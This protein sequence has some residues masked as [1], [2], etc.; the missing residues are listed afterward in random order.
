MK[1]IFL[2]L[3]FF[4]T[5]SANAYEFFDTKTQCNTSSE[6]N[7]PN[8]PK[9]SCRMHVVRTAPGF[10]FAN[11][12]DDPSF[13]F[14]DSNYSIS[15][16]KNSDPLPIRFIVLDDEKNYNAIQAIVQTAYATRAPL[17]INFANPTTDI[18][19]EDSFMNSKKSG[20]LEKR[21]YKVANLKGK[22]ILIHCPIQSI[23]LGSN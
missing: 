16:D 20:T 21:C 7:Q 23:Q 22:T 17:S 12:S 13:F 8:I 10:N 5:I 3:A 2:T 9:K 6:I 18:L 1:T 19:D 14:F 4:L 11:S 15:L